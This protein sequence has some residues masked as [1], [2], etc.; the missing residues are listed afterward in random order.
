[1]AAAAFAA[2]V[3]LSPGSVALAAV[4]FE[5]PFHPSQCDTALRWSAGRLDAEPDSL[6]ARRT[7]AEALLCRGLTG[8]GAEALDQALAALGALRSENPGD[9]FTLLYLAEAQS[10]RFPLSR[11]AIS[12]FAAAAALLPAADV[13]AAR[14]PLAR[15][16]RGRLES[17]A[18]N[19]A[20]QLP[21]L[22]SQLERHQR[23]LLEAADRSS[24]LSR[25]AQTGPAGL[26]R[27]RQLRQQSPTGATAIQ[28]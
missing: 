7:H 22:A 17:I 27:A 19:Q 9:P 25:L 12:H 13:G 10:R 18:G 23:G 8:G 16:I 1:M 24:L 26:A 6:L 5:N 14:E 28:R 3:A 2:A 4:G 20:I 21:I 15:H 11:E